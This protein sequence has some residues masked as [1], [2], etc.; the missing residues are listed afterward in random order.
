MIIKTVDLITIQ[1]V[2]KSFKQKDFVLLNNKLYSSN[3][4]YYLVTSGFP[5]D[6]MTP[7]LFKGANIAL[8]APITMLTSFLIILRHS[9]YFSP[10]LK[11][12]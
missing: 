12:L 1:N 8:L 7:I 6:I 2:A 5:T 9:S 11:R 10:S 4:N 3:M